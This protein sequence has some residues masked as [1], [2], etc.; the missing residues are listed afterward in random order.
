MILNDLHSNG[1]IS[2]QNVI[3][4]SLI[5]VTHINITPIISVNSIS[6]VLKSIV[7]VVCVE[8]KDS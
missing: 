6:Q 5:D 3:D 7:L 8:G 4:Y 1:F 2:T